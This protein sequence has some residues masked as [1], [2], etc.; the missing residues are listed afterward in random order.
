MDIGYAIRDMKENRVLIR[1]W[2]PGSLPFKNLTY[3]TAKEELV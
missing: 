2:D 1:D 3:S